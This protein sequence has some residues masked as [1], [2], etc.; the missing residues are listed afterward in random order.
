[1]IGAVAWSGFQGYGVYQRTVLEKKVLQQIV[2]RL[3]ADSRIAEVLVT[4]V[5]YNP[6]TR[7]QM[8][9][10]KFL[11]YN[12][13]GKPLWP[14]YF[15][16]AGNVIQFQSL[17]VRFADDLVEMGDELRGKSIYLFWK[18]FVLEGRQT[19]EHAI[20]KVN[21]VP[22]GYKVGD[23]RNE[24]EEQIWQRFWE[25]ALNSEHAVTK[26]IKNAQIEAPGTKFVPGILYTLKIEHDGGIRIDATK[27]P[28]ILRG[29][30]IY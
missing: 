30:T 4:G 3:R 22:A 13:E 9:T 20:T 23:V 12:S 10:I 26:G 5:E 14:R 16:F 25:Y 21:E 11:E 19:Q 27:I 29:E 24:Y 28:A 2:Q 8:T 7:Q 17:V 18:A 6:V 1:M 15:T